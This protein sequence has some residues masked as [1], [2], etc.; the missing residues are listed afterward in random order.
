M[1]LP[2]LKI[3]ILGSEYKQQSEKHVNKSDQKTNL[4]GGGFHMILYGFYMI[5]FG[6]HM[7]LH[8]F[9]MILYSFYMIFHDFV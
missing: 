9:D 8:G 2:D 6:V 5:L 3:S 7:I 4:R 1:D